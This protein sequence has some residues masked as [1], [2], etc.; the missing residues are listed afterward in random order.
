MIRDQ[1]GQLYMAVEAVTA[2]TFNTINRNQ[3]GHVFGE[4]V[5]CLFHPSLS[6]RTVVTE[7]DQVCLELGTFFHL[8]GVLDKQTAESN[9][10]ARDFVNEMLAYTTKLRERLRGE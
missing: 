6:L 2:G 9:G 4:S 3:W 8:A 7:I 10:W 5:S 1:C